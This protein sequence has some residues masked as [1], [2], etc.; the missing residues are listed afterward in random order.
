MDSDPGPCQ[1]YI[2]KYY[3]DR[4]RGS[5][6]QFAYGGCQGNGNRFGT[7]EE[8]EHYC[9]RLEEPKTS[10]TPAGNNDFYF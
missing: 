4:S 2:I 5:C 1:G 9:G 3:F 7:V 6:I 10:L 8:C